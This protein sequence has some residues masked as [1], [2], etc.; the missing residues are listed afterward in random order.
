[1]G[2]MLLTTIVIVT[3][4]A[5]VR[6][7]SETIHPIE[8]VFFR[9]IFG[10]PLMLMLMLRRGGASWRLHRPARHLLRSALQ[11][12]SSFCFFF[13][14]T[15]R[16]LSEV[17]VVT[18]LSPVMATVLAVAFLGERVGVQR[19]LAIVVGFAGTWV[20]M[21]PDAGGIA[22]GS[23]VALGGALAWALT[24]L[25]LNVQ[26]R[27]DATVT[28]VFYSALMTSS[29]ALVPA[30]FVWQWP[31]PVAWV[32]LVGIGLLGAL[33]NVSITEALRAGDPT[34]V[35]PLDFLRLVW[36]TAVG[37]F[38]FGD[39]ASVETWI[40]GAMI[41]ASATYIGVREGRSRRDG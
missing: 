28:I 7:V 25:L 11:V 15:S 19:W 22:F 31:E 3:M 23:G 39:P 1:M 34:A 18:F 13:A 5:L 24:L 29:I 14:I 6:T 41:F 9:N 4:Q 21:R 36:A 33:N 17:T 40:G 37:V 35:L 20:V 10:A 8:I 2:F 26:G 32:L 38:M 12:T 30:L 16:P 27:F